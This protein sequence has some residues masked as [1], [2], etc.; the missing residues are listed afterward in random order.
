M[1]HPV[2]FS[3]YLP[4]APS[5]PREVKLVPIRTDRDYHQ[6]NM[7]WNA[8]EYPNGISELFQYQIQKCSNGICKRSFPFTMI[9]SL[10]SPSS[11][12]FLIGGSYGGGR[13]DAYTEY[14][15]SVREQT[16]GGC[17]G[18]YSDKVTKMTLSGSK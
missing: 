5:K 3:L 4:L 11:R 2:L 17:W 18:D 14:S 13:L 12:S 16:C 10:K 1:E 8:P 6:I 15:V 9:H 7:T